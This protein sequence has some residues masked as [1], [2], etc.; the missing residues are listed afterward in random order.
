MAA[1]PRTK[2]N[3]DFFVTGESYAG[4]YIAVVT[5]HT[6]HTKKAKP[7]DERINL[8]GMAIGNGLCAAVLRAL[9]RCCRDCRAV[10][11]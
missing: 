1:R 3:A 4:H 2:P 5:H 9:R 8:K 7:E 10:T 11:E 6:W